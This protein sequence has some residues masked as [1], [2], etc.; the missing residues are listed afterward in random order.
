MEWMLDSIIFNQGGYWETVYSSNQVA[1]SDET[2]EAI[3]K[4]RELIVEDAL[5]EQLGILELENDVT[6]EK[7]VKV[8]QQVIED[9]NTVLGKKTDHAKALEDMHGSMKAALEK[10]TPDEAKGVLEMAFT[11]T[12][13][14]KPTDQLPE[15]RAKAIETEFGTDPTAFNDDENSLRKF[16]MQ[17]KNDEALS[18]LKD[19]NVDPAVVL[20]TKFVR[21]V[22]HLG[23]DDTVRLLDAIQTL[24][25]H[26]NR[27]GYQ[28]NLLKLAIDD[29]APVFGN[30]NGMPKYY[31]P[32]LYEAVRKHRFACLMELL[33]IEP[34]VDF[35]CADETPL[36]LAVRTLQPFFVSALLSY[37][38]N[39]GLKTPEKTMNL[40]HLLCSIN[41]HDPDNTLYESW[42][43]FGGYVVGEDLSEIPKRRWSL[44]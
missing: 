13:L 32:A 42:P 30:V 28:D 15:E 39:L 22:A 12:I 43:R 14:F 6:P 37:G 23:Y 21:K 27:K 44:T 8:K 3:I 33:R 25:L 10:L 19:N 16:C 41:F 1:E 9:L 34:M 31:A 5:Q 17:A 20:T 11:C 24:L 2:R 40:M 38:A 36:L 18:L 35:I 26:H 7:L 4:Q 29:T